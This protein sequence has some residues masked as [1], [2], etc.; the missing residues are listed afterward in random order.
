MKRHFKRFGWIYGSALVLIIWPAMVWRMQFPEELDKETLKKMRTAL[1]QRFKR[2]HPD[3]H[4]INEAPPKLPDIIPGEITRLVNQEPM[5][6][7]SDIV[8]PEREKVMQFYAPQ[9]KWLQEMN[10]R[11]GIA[12]AGKFTDFLSVQRIAKLHRAEANRAVNQKDWANALQELQNTATAGNPIRYAELIGHLVAVATRAIAYGGYKYLLNADAPMDVQRQALQSLIQLRRTDPVLDPETTFSEMIYALT[13]QENDNKKPNE[14]SAFLGSNIALLNL[15]GAISQMPDRIHDPDLR[16]WA[17]RFARSDHHQDG[18]GMIFPR[19][20]TD[21]PSTERWLNQMIKKEPWVYKHFGFT[22]AEYAQMDP[23]TLALSVGMDPFF[24]N[25]DEIQARTRTTITIGRLTEAAFAARI[26][27]QEH[28]GQ[29]P[30]SMEDLQPLLA[31]ADSRP[32]TNTLLYSKPYYPLNMGWHDFN[33]DPSPLI[34]MWQQVFPRLNTNVQSL[35]MYRDHDN[36]WVLDYRTTDS[37]WNTMPILAIAYAEALQ[38]HPAVANHVDVAKVTYS[39]MPIPAMPPMPAGSFATTDTVVRAFPT[40]TPTPTPTPA[41][42]GYGYGGY[43]AP[44]SMSHFASTP[45]TPEEAKLLTY[46]A[47]PSPKLRTV[48]VRAR[49]TAPAKSFILWSPG[50]DGKD[51]YGSV[52]YD[53]SNGTLSR[54]DLVV[55]AERF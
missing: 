9:M 46:G 7:P 2:V 47:G 36:Q 1:L 33:G 11:N 6:V 55:F 34:T 41:V 28:G 29:W 4:I 50:P 15:A 12:G 45:L 44:P 14:K 31:Q 10:T 32:T 37:E 22:E 3:L 35:N 20:W 8:S 21:I 43:A 23:W 39:D 26:Y 19:H 51:D 24:F 48:E 30:Q 18:R 5:V 40:P 17:I 53:P 38:Q 25:S 16:A 13:S 49:L 54:G 52:V 42:N 27:Q